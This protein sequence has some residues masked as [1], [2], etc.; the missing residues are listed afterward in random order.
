M[1]I[2]NSYP[3][4][5]SVVLSP[6][7]GYINATLLSVATSGEVDVLTKSYQWQYYLTGIASWVDIAGNS[8]NWIS[9][10]LGDVRCIVT[11]SNFY[12][13]TSFTSNTITIDTASDA[14]P[15]PVITSI[16]ISPTDGKVGTTFTVSSTATGSSDLTVSYKWRVHSD[17]LWFDTGTAQSYTL[18]NALALADQVLCEVTYT[19]LFGRSVSSSA[20]VTPHATLTDVTALINPTVSTGS[21]SGPPYGSKNIVYPTVE[22][23]QGYK[24]YLTK[25]SLKNCVDTTAAGLFFNADETLTDATGTVFVEV[26]KYRDTTAKKAWHYGMVVSTQKSGMAQDDLSNIIGV[27]D[28]TER[29]HE[30][31]LNSPKIFTDQGNSIYTHDWDEIIQLKVVH[32]AE[33]PTY[34]NTDMNHPEVIRIYINNKEILRW[35]TYNSGTGLFFSS[36]ERKTTFYSEIEPW[37]KFLPRKLRLPLTPQ[38]GKIFGVYS[39]AWSQY[40]WATKRHADGTYDYTMNT[41]TQKPEFLE[42][43]ATQAVLIGAE[44]N[45]YHRTNQYLTDLV[46]NKNMNTNIKSYIMQT[47]PEVVGMNYYDVPYTTPAAT[48]VDVEPVSYLMYYVPEDTQSGQKY[49]KGL[50]V[51]ER[52]AI[53]STPINTG[54]RA[55]MLIQNNMPHLVFLKKDPDSKNTITVNLSLWT[56]EIIANSD[57]DIIES[58]IDRSNP[59]EVIQI[60]SQWIQSTYAAE[61]I[62]TAVAAGIDGFSNDVSLQIFGNPLIQVGD[63]VDLS[64]S[65]KGI[66]HTYYLVQSV[67]QSFK[68]GLET[69]LVLNKVK[70]GTAFTPENRFIITDME[71]I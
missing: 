47:R 24:T 28:I 4:I 49:M 46:L 45:Y 17:S 5:S 69:T 39:S 70:N 57:Q 41:K 23:D 37:E 33:S 20:S 29:I 43:Y 32:Y 26:V 55:R 31:Y 13:S 56:H 51:N 66:N 38:V 53:Y 1:T 71:I 19:D 60:D 8:A 48:T 16:S 64:Y 22:R 58:I 18:G 7:I 36:P 65:L 52:G 2:Y 14:G 40:S 67:Q 30:L 12:G 15:A 62:M 35:D 27:A 50:T 34:G 21:P 59:A 25:F 44:E 9:T 3:S 54:F 61:K 42:L 63:V 6:S 10:V 68:D 11:A